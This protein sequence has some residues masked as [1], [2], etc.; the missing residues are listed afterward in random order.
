MP[1][2]AIDMIKIPK[3]IHV[4]E[5]VLDVEC[6]DGHFRNYLPWYIGYLGCDSDPQSDG[7]AKIEPS[8]IDVQVSTVLIREFDELF[9]PKGAIE[10]AMKN[11]KKNIVIITGFEYSPFFEPLGSP[12]L[13]IELRDG[14]RLFQWMV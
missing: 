7:I 6:G 3:M 10:R 9:N 11:A 1:L 5:T 4:G 14:I 2:D 13:T 12:E 8:K